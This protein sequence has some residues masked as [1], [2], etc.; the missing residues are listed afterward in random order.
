MLHMV[1]NLFIKNK[2]KFLKHKLCNDTMFGIG[3]RCMWIVEREQLYRWRGYE[4]WRE[5]RTCSKCGFVTEEDYDY[6]PKCGEYGNERERQNP[7]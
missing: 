1:C 4:E 5:K 6:C 3:E 2:L 7:V